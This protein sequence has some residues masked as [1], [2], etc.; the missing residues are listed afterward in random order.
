M[1]LVDG[2]S[3]PFDNETPT[4]VKKFVFSVAGKIYKLRKRNYVSWRHRGWKINYVFHY[5]L[6]NKYYFS[7]CKRVM[8]KINYECAMSTLISAASPGR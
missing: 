7:V 3:Q 4:L 2:L 1:L 8:C 6:L 5:Y